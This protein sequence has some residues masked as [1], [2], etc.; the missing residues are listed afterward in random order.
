MKTLLP[1]CVPV[2]EYKEGLG[3]HNE[4]LMF[5]AEIISKIVKE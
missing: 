4:S 5:A 3:T 2:K 1:D